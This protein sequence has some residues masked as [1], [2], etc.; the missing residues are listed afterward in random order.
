VAGAGVL[1]RASRARRE[2]PT[3]TAAAPP[4]SRS[5]W[6]RG[7]TLY[8]DH[9]LRALGHAVAVVRADEWPRNDRPW[10]PQ[11]E[12]GAPEQAPG[13][14]GDADAAAAGAPGDACRAARLKMVAA[15]VAAA[16]EEDPSEA[17]AWRGG[18]A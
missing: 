2:R 1:G 17:R 6:P 10:P 12:Q 11:R 13:G 4:A 8:R 18:G 3:L 14:G 9:L 7:N 5:R 15:A 16:L